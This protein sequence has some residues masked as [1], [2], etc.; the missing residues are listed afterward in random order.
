MSVSSNLIPR[1]EWRCAVLWRIF[2]VVLLTAGM[3]LMRATPASANG[4]ECINGAWHDI[5]WE[6][7]DR[8]FCDQWGNRSVT[9]VECSLGPVAVPTP[10]PTTSGSSGGSTQVQPGTSAITPIY[11]SVATSKVYTGTPTASDIQATINVW[12]K[13]N[14]GSY[15]IYVEAGREA[16]PAYV[17]GGAAVAAMDSAAILAMLAN[18]ATWGIVVVGGIVTAIVVTSSSDL[19]SLGD[20]GY[21]WEEVSSLASQGTAL[22]ARRVGE[23][24]SDSRVLMGRWTINNCP[25]P[26]KHI[27]EERGGDKCARLNDAK[28]AWGAKLV[29]CYESTTG[30]ARMMVRLTG[31]IWGIAYGDRS[32]FIFEK[33]S[34]TGFREVGKT[35]CTDTMEYLQEMA[36]LAVQVSC[37]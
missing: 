12:K 21:T 32:T 5:D 23:L 24:Y 33:K 22:Q 1:A 9:A 25:P 20:L 2:F 36:R 29:K 10:P 34:S 4:P 15:I 31:E 7:K 6:G 18:P 30:P 13:I 37:P 27:C 3:V 11:T 26:I 16:Y 17:L 8:G 28:Q 35:W 14:A 19:A